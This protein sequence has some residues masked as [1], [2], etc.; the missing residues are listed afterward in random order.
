MLQILVKITIFVQEIN[1]NKP[2]MQEDSKHKRTVVSLMFGDV[3]LSV[4]NKKYRNV[5]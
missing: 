1:P 5:L 2:K 3:K 4:A